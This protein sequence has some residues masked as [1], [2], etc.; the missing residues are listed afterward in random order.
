MYSSCH[1]VGNVSETSIITQNGLKVNTIVIAQQ[2][3]I[4]DALKP[5]D[6]TGY[7]DHI[8]VLPYQEVIRLGE[9][10]SKAGLLAKPKDIAMI[11]YTS[12]STGSPKGVLMSHRNLVNAMVAFS[13]VT[14]IYEDDVYMAYLPL[15]HVLEFLAGEKC[16]F[17]RSFTGSFIYFHFTNHHYSFLWKYLASYPRLTLLLYSQR[18]CACSTV[19][20]LDIR[21]R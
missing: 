1:H 4:E 8:K 11:M 6:C 9:M 3:A 12:G 17:V 16:S 7:G 18:V 13:S 10:S 2:I 19:C 5:L 14:T 20:Q 15:A 21:R